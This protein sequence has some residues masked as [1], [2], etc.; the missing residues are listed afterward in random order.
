MLDGGASRHSGPTVENQRQMRALVVTNMWP[1]PEAPARGAFVRDQVTALRALPGVEVEVFAFPP[2]GYARAA[3][4]LRRRHRGEDFDVVHAHFGLTAWPALALRGA[5]HVVTLHGTDVRHP[6]SGRITRAALPLVDLVATV[7]APLAQELD[8]RPGRLRSRV[9]RAVLPC[10][11]DTTR[12][13]PLPR[14]QARERLGLDPAEPCV[15]FPADPARAVKRADRAREAAGD[16]R[17]LTLGQV[18]PAEVPLW[19]NAANAVLVP[20]DAEGFGLAVLE[21]LA[22]DVPVL[23]TPVGAHSAVLSG[24]AGTLCA[25]YDRDR[26]RAALAPHLASP[27]PRVEGRARAASW[28]AEHMA[29]R[30]LAAWSELTGAPVYLAAD[31]PVDGALSV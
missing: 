6:R 12:F 19:I 20:S 30:V 18:E 2:G 3:L 27:D 26:W 25:P 11:V 23:A 14:L 31:A 10:G 22:C 16:A 21:A 1:S 9:P 4:A 5:P 29:R 15:L 8:A 7:S 17:L 24:I 28:S 13:A